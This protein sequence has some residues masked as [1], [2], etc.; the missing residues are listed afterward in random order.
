M[1]ATGILLSVRLSLIIPI[2]TVGVE[3]GLPIEQDRSIV[4]LFVAVTATISPILF[5]VFLPPIQSII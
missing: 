1:L 4:I 5:R 3:L 2:A